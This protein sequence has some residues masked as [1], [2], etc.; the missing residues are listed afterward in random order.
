[1]NRD[2]T[3]LRIL[4]EADHRDPLRVVQPTQP[5]ATTEPAIGSPTPI[6]AEPT[7]TL[8]EP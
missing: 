7:A 4:V 6:P 2:G 3:D 8:G 5:E 1:M